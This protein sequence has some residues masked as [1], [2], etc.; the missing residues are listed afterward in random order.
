MAT[1]ITQGLRR[2]FIKWLERGLKSDAPNA[3]EGLPMYYAPTNKQQVIRH[4]SRMHAMLIKFNGELPS[5][6]AD[7]FNRRQAQLRSAN[8]HVDTLPEILDMLAKF[9]ALRDIRAVPRPFR[10]RT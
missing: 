4:L 10:R 2:H 3:M 7:E 8:I 1:I 9:G 5:S 6:Y